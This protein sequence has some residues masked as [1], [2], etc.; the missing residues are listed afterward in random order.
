[1]LTLLTLALTFIAVAIVAHLE[2]TNRTRNIDR[3]HG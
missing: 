2:H 3:Y 1:M